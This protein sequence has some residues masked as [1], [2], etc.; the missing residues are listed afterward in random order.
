MLRKDIL[1]NLRSLEELWDKLDDLK[2]K[3]EDLDFRWEEEIRKEWGNVE[4]E[5]V[6]VVVDEILV[7]TEEKTT[8]F[9]IDEENAPPDI[10]RRR[11]REIRET[12]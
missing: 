6:K 9:E 12:K 4:L 5:K 1:M 7:R 8:R 10:P 2:L 3:K 11:R